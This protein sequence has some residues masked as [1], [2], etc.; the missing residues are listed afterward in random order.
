MRH[1]NKAELQ[2]TGVNA[3]SSSSSSSSSSSNR[4][5]IMY[6]EM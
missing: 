4:S 5:N 3:C 6:T 1:L 2:L